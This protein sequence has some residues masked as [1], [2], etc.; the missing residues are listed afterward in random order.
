VIQP[1]TGALAGRVALVTGA[2]RGIGVG[3]ATCLAAAGA[4]LALVARTASDLEAT[5]GAVR[6]LG[7]RALPIVADVTNEAD[8]D[9]IVRTTVGELD[10]LDVLA[11]NAGTLRVRRF[12]DHDVAAWD[13]SFAVN[14]RS[15][16][17]CS[18]AAARAMVA[19]GRG[20]RIVMTSSHYAD[21]AHEGFVAYC[22]SK[23]AVEAI[24]RNLAL[25]LGPHGITVNALRVGPV[26]S[27]L[28]SPESRAESTA[29]RAGLEAAGH[30]RGGPPLGRAGRPE[31]VGA[32]VVFLASDAASW[33]TG[34]SMH[35]DGGI[36]LR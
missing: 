9:R 6:A 5:A 15:V 2:G 12:L 10:R 25:E 31:E 29:I 16:F 8:V 18:R 35:V 14:T 1:P 33:I 13:E 4:D 30:R 17:L 23:A 34:A 7:V 20:G 28:F 24:A 32:A 19:G 26:P 27:T 11:N 22:A 21:E 3:I 36:H